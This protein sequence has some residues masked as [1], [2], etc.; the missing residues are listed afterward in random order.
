MMPDWIV[1]RLGA[2]CVF[3]AFLDIILVSQQF[4]A[5]PT[6]WASAVGILRGFIM[7]ALVYTALRAYSFDQIER[8]QF[9]VCL[10]FA[11]GAVF[12]TLLIAVSLKQSG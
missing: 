3:I 5:E 7:L 12:W 10:T 1:K 9:Y 8:A 2:A 6:I 11:M 4:F